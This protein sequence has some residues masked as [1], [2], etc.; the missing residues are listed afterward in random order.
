LTHPAVADAAVFGIPNE[1]MGEE[2]KAIQRLDIADAGSELA[3]E[4]HRLL[5]RPPV[6]CQMPALDRLYR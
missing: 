4:T 1:E 6:A 2:V 3:A 5:P